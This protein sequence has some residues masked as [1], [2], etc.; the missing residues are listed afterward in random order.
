MCLVAKQCLTLC[1]PMDCS[2]PGSS[3]HGDSLGENTGVGCHA[4]LII[5]NSRVVSLIQDWQTHG[6]YYFRLC[7]TCAC[8]A[9]Q[10]GLTLCDPMGCGPPG[11]SVHGI[12]QARILTG[13]PS[14]PPGDLPNPGIKRWSP[15]L[16]A[17]SLPSEPPRTSVKKKKKN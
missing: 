8:L 10:S 11:S 9:A 3:V 6:M 16:Q 7:N 1:N 12:L 13:L 14:P 5:Y 2:P 15:A 4:L 17:D